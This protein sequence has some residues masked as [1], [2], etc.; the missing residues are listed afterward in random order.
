MWVT[1]HNSITAEK[2][3]EI[4]KG[5]KHAGND[6]AKRTYYYCKLHGDCKIGKGL[7]L[8]VT[9]IENGNFLLQTQGE[10][11][12]TT[13]AVGQV[14][15]IYPTIA[16][17]VDEDI[18]RG[19]SAQKILDGIAGDFKP[20]L[21]QVYNRRKHLVNRKGWQIST[22]DD[23]SF[24][25]ESRLV[26]TAEKFNNIADDDK[27]VIVVHKF[28]APTTKDGET[29]MQPGFIFTS[30]SILMNMKRRIEHQR[31][32]L[33]LALDGTWKLTFNGW[34]LIVLATQEIVRSSMEKDGY[35]GAEKFRNSAK[36]FMFLFFRTE[37]EAATREL[38]V[39]FKKICSE[40]LHSSAAISTVVMDHCQALANGVQ[41]ASPD[42]TILDCWA[43]LIRKFMLKAKP[44][45]ANVLDKEN[46]YNTMKKN[47]GLLHEARSSAMFKLM[48]DLF[49]EELREI[50]EGQIATWFQGVYLAEGWENWY[51]VAA[52]CVGASIT[53][54]P[55][56]SWNRL[57]KRRISRLMS[58]TY[59]IN[60][61]IQV[62][63]DTAE[64]R[65]DV[66]GY[67]V[68]QQ[69]N[70][71]LTLPIPP[72]MTTNAC[73]HVARD[74]FFKG[75]GTTLPDSTF[76]N[77]RALYGTPVTE[78][79]VLQYIQFKFDN[80]QENLIPRSSEETASSWFHRTVETWSQAPGATTSRQ[81]TPPRNFT[82]AAQMMLTLH[83]VQDIRQKEDHKLHSSHAFICD[84][85]MF[86]STGGICSHVLAV[87]HLE[88]IRSLKPNELVEIRGP[89]RQRKRSLALEQER[90]FRQINVGDH[91]LSVELG[92]GIV[93]HVI[94]NRTKC[95]VHWQQ[96]PEESQTICR[97]C[98]DCER[99]PGQMHSQI[100][101][102]D[103]NIMF[104]HMLQT[105]ARPLR[106]I[107][108]DDTLELV[109]ELD[110]LAVDS[111]YDQYS[112][113]SQDVDIDHQEVQAF[114]SD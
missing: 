48:A 67:N 52:G 9:S 80:L 111:D 83:E 72:S 22:L 84:C 66:P 81:L 33:C 12:G 74:A 86:Q 5:F 99:F 41:A 49:I 23:L 40:W 113:E 8:K 53:N 6:G 90:V 76:F 4:C 27:S 28:T 108:V 14:H 107:P 36:P 112:D 69:L 68:S 77:S 60:H 105:Y 34:V 42:T 16:N 88:G 3:K 50:G 37:T 18:H 62:V 96:V 59:F 95:I 13:I 15:G 114:D 46:I 44:M 91:L 110:A 109:D 64:E 47:I 25:M 43:H 104:N 93:V 101:I 87:C 79:R 32:G 100:T 89:G 65:F 54:N 106:H 102:A 7:Q 2:R 75:V 82:D 98:P 45:I 97:L 56:E 61:G 31:Y 17:Q 21:E 63:V 55:L 57:L 58:M 71:I 38:M 26:D 1:Q 19:I 35:E 78:H 73:A 39:T 10:H 70:D 30:K 11:S 29:I 51:G 94:A 24:W 103:A 85:L 20:T 92:H